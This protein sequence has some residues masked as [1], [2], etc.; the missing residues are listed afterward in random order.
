MFSIFVPII[1]MSLLSVTQNVAGIHSLG[2]IT[3]K[4]KQ[5][6]A[7]E[8][9]HYI[10]NMS[11]YQKLS[12]ATLEASDVCIKMVFCLDFFNEKLQTKSLKL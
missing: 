8:V 6:F 7:S 12:L 2:I 9:M 1:K 3:N 11:T 4:T 5:D 10:L